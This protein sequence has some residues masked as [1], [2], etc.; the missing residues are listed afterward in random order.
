MS[1]FRKLFPLS[2]KTSIKSFFNRHSATVSQT[3][4][5]YWIYG[6]AFNEKRAGYFI[7]IGAHDGVY[8]SNTYL[9]ES[10]YGWSGICIE[11]NPFTFQKLGENRRSSNLNICLDVSEGEVSF[12]LRGVLGGIIDHDVDNKVSDAGNNHI[13]KLRT[14]TLNRI[15]E[16][17]HV[18]G[19][20]DYL[21]I[22]VEG[23]EERI[24]TSFNFDKYIFRCITIERPTESLRNILKHH[25]YILIKDIPG[26]DCFYIHQDFL[27]EY[28]YNL[29]H[30]YN[31]RQLSIRW[32]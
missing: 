24:L 22:D 12:A 6:E 14:K 13:I 18:P 7:D 10:K 29:F 9:L 3:G 5:D 8:H 19:I 16:E 25:R 4:Q 31:K 23:A 2:L 21:S 15:F 28:K 1:P 20:I 26:L 30:F 17:H 11:A 32:R 27:E